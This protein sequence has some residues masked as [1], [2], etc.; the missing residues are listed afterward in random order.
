MGTSVRQCDPMKLREQRPLTP[1][2]RQVLDLMLSQDFPG[3]TSL[4]SQVPFVRVVG[5][6][7]CGCPTVDLEVAPKAPR[8]TGDFPSRVIPVTGYVGSTVDEPGAG[9]IVFVDEGYLSGLE[10]Y[11][12]ADP[13]PQEWPDL[14]EIRVVKDI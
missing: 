7:D 9:I 13:A 5:K 12:M 14:G 10:I 4:R 1:R 8:A 2:E 6:C 11:T 3:A